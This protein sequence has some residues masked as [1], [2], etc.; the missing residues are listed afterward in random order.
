MARQNN[1]K[2]FTDA[3]QT[4]YAS[5]LAEIKNGRKKSHWMWY[6]FPQLLGL[7]FTETSRFY[8]IENI[9]EAGEYLKH[10]VLG[11]RL[12]EICDQLLQLESND[13]YKIFGSPDDLKLKSSMTLFTVL[14]ET[15][16][17]FQ[18]V[19]DKFFKGLKDDKTLQIL[20]H[21]SK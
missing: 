6:I 5:A 10:P 2:R 17:V 19:L 8:S 15:D 7:G 12:V 18:L 4:D 20:K 21:Q 16:K 14:P 9:I 1:L 11:S 13:A 3:Q